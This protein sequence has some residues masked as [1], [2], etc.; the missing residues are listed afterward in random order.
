MHAQVMEN[1]QLAWATFLSGGLHAKQWLAA[2]KG[3]LRRLE[4][5]LSERHIRA[6]HRC[7]D[8]GGVGDAW[9]RTCGTSSASSRTWPHWPVRR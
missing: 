1:L 3:V 2:G 6:P 5:E 7:S 8:E 9:L 4:K